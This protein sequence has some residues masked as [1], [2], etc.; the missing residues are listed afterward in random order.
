LVVLTLCLLLDATEFATAEDTEAFPEVVTGISVTTT[1]LGGTTVDFF[2]LVGLCIDSVTLS[3]SSSFGTNGTGCKVAVDN[4]S[5]ECVLDFV[6]DDLTRSIGDFSL[7][8]LC[9]SSIHTDGDLFFTIGLITLK[10]K[11]F[12]CIFKFNLKLKVSII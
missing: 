1:V 3:I 11:M 4:F 7:D 2:D 8:K 6:V 12:E 9:D 5:L 10:Q